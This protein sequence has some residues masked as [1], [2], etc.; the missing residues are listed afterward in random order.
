MGKNGFSPNLIYMAPPLYSL[1]LAATIKYINGITTQ[2]KGVEKIFDVSLKS[3]M[4]YLKQM[5]QDSYIHL[6]G[7]F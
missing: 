4:R 7:V 3:Y 6:K 5:L 2:Y 1:Q